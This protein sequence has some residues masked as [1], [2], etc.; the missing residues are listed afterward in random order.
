MAISIGDIIPSLKMNTAQKL[1]TVSSTGG[2]KSKGGPTIVSNKDKTTLNEWLYENSKRPALKRKICLVQG[3]LYN[4]QKKKNILTTKKDKDGNNKTGVWIDRA[5][6]AQ[7]FEGGKKYY[8]KLAHNT[9]LLCV[10]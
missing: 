1:G 6:I 4:D 10:Q 8:C 5:F 9:L 3:S 7:K 2:G